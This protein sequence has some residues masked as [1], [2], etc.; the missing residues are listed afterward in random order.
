MQSRTTVQKWNQKQV[1]PRVTDSPNLPHGTLVKVTLV[2]RPLLTPVAQSC[3]GV[4]MVYSRAEHVLIPEHY[5][6]SKSFAAVREAHNN[7]YRDKEVPNK[8]IIHRLVTTFRDTGS[9]CLWQVLIERQNSWN[10]GR[11]DFKQCISC[12]NGIR[13]QELH[14]ATGSLLLCVKGFMCCSLVSVLNATFCSEI[15][16]SHGDEYEDDLSSGMLRRVFW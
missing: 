6:A 12:N 11:T 4:N 16:G 14:R 15:S 2:A 7:A 10:H 9:V 8:T 5:F 1:H 3:A 13:L